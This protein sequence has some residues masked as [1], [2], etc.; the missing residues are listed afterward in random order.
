MQCLCDNDGAAVDLHA[1]LH[2][3]I[4]LESFLQPPRNSCAY[5]FINVMFLRFAKP[6]GA[7]AQQMML[8]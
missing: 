4:G 3:K 6:I 2:R 8:H 7:A 5:S 1:R